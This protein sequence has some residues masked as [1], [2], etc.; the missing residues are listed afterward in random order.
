MIKRNKPTTNH[1][2]GLTDSIFFTTKHIKMNH[3]NLIGK[4]TSLP[5]IYE[6]PNGRKIAQFTMSTKETY[7]DEEGNPKNKSN[8]HRMSAWGNW[9]N[10]LQELS[11]VGTELAVEGKLNT[12]FYEKA[13]QKKFIS[14]VEI[15]DLI[16]L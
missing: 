2:V 14:E 10:V 3:V 4:I 9:V 6:L 8:W 16:I 1:G 7:L 11:E 13:G 5:R 15:N 12:R